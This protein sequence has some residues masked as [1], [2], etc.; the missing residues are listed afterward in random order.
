MN[1]T[2]LCVNPVMMVA[3]L[4]LVLGTNYKVNAMS[5]AGCDSPQDRS[6]RVFHRFNCPN[7]DDALVPLEHPVRNSLNKKFRTQ[8][9]IGEINNVVRVGD[10]G[11]AYWWKKNSSGKSIS[12]TPVAIKFQGNGLGEA[13]ITSNVIDVFKSWGVS[14]NTANCVN[15]LLNASGI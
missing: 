10:Y 6:L 5:R 15:Q 4:G 12:A 7:L 11:A 3:I 14:P 8:G 2:F 1:K 9:N 13:V